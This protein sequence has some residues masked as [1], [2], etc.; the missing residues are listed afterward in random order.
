M[1]VYRC[2]M[3]QWALDEHPSMKRII[4]GQF[5]YNQLLTINE[6]GYNIYYLPNYPSVY[7]GGSVEGFDIDKFEYVFVDMD[8][9]DKAYPNKE[10]FIEKLNKFKLK[11]SKII[12]SGNGIHA[13]W[14][15]IDLDAKSYLRLQR[16]L[17]RYFNT[18]EAVGQIYQLMRVP[19]TVNT[20]VR[21]DLKLCELIAETGA[22]YTCEQ[23]DSALPSLT[24]ADEQYCNHH[25]DKTYNL[26]SKNVVVDDKIPLKFAKLL[27]SNSEVKDIWSGKSE[28]R[29]VSDYRL[30]H[31]MFSAGF[32]KEEATSVLVNSAKALSRAPVHRVNYAVNIIDK[33]WVYEESSEEEPELELATSVRDIL[34]KT[35]DNTIQGTRFRCHSY[36]DDTECGFRLSQVI[37]LVAGSG[38]G[39]TAIALNMFEGFVTNN[40]EYDHIFVSL[41]QTKKEIAYRWK[42]I[43]VDREYLYDRVHIIDNYDKDGNFRD[44]SLEE[45]RQYVLKFQ[46]DKKRKIGCVVIDHIAVL[47]NDNRLGIDEGTK[48][49]CK[50]MKVFAVTT[51]TLLIMQSQTSRE[52]AGIGDLELNKDAAFGT[53]SF[54]NWCDYLI[55]LWQP[56]KRCY[57]EK[58]PT[59]TAFKFCKIRHKE[60]DKDKIQEDVCYKLMFDSKTNR[61][62]ELT[63]DEETQFTFYLN[64]ATNKRKQDRKTELV[65]YV[66]ATFGTGGN[67]V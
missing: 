19:G 37:G 28:D 42:R 60:S 17:L 38:V 56:L 46:S 15:T 67:E 23:L 24:M 18:D 64:R 59:V 20:K 32:T 45:I 5:D 49:L 47:R 4:E 35:D 1:T 14:R 25:Y 61:L 41:E 50:E 3:P 34:S 40:P 44:L 57:R 33:I 31:I 9:K 48:K 58:A 22:E 2:I 6:Q 11:P 66:S 7:N 29:S 52:K 55:T 43:C 8:L 51:N 36:I 62:R 12:D 65:E 63:Q 21:D 16:R 13:Y 30:G 54:E 10:S 27:K 26:E 39:K 53:S